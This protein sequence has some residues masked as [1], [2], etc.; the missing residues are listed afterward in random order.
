[1]TCVGESAGERPDIPERSAQYVVTL[2]A[3]EGGRVPDITTA[4]AVFSSGNLEG[5]G[6]QCICVNQLFFIV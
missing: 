6:I 1:M 4:I 2:P 5:Q 3:R